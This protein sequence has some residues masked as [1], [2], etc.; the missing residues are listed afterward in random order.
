MYINDKVVNISKSIS[1]NEM[2]HVSPDSLQ[3]VIKQ[4]IRDNSI[5][6]RHLPLSKKAFMSRT[7]LKRTP[8]IIDGYNFYFSYIF[9]SGVKLDSDIK[10]DDLL[11]AEDN[12]FIGDVK[13]AVLDNLLDNPPK[14]EKIGEDIYSWNAPFIVGSSINSMHFKTLG[15]QRKV[16]SD[17]E[18]ER[19]REIHKDEREEEKRKREMGKKLDKELGLDKKKSHT[20]ELARFR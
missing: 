10:L 18:L 8:I 19:N 3:G 14:I 5:E 15:P 12:T 9:E 20:R 7:K 16:V 1:F 6:N 17:A 11:E 2:F 13:D 4:I